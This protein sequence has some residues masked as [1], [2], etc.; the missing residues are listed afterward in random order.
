MSSKCFVTEL[1]GFEHDSIREILK[2]IDAN[3]KGICFV[4]DKQGVLVGS[5][6]DGDVRR[7]LLKNFGL[8]VPVKEI[9]KREF[10][11]LPIG[12]PVEEIQEMLSSTIRY[13]PLVDKN[14]RPIDYASWKRMHRIP[15]MEPTLIGNEIAYVTDCIKTGWI[16]SQGHYVREFE[17]LLAGYCSMPYALA[18]SNGT[19]ALHLALLALGVSKGDQ[20]I[21]PDIT[22]AACINAVIYTGATPV[23]VDVSRDTWSLDP[24]AVEKAITSRT[25]VIMSVH[26]YGHPCHMDELSLISKKHNIFLIEDCAEALG[27][28]YKD[29]PIGSFGDISIF[30]FFGNKTITTGEGGMVL[31]RDK[32]TYERAHV[33]RDHGMSKV[34]KYWHDVVGYNYRM[35][36]LQGAIGVAQLERLNE[37]IEAK[38][39]IAHYYNKSF[40]SFDEIIIPP[41]ET[42][43]YNSFWLY[44]ILL[45]EKVTISRDDLI[46]ELLK[47]GIESRPT[48][49]PIHQMPIYKSY[50]DG[51]QNFPVAG[52]IS[53]NGISLP[54]SVSL[55]EK[56]QDS[57]IDIVIHF[58]LKVRKKSQLSNECAL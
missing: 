4:V 5:V 39:K 52:Y 34:K 13:I 45:S 9:M 57:I 35:T 36:N 41:E 48:F 44:T 6:T 55:S 53:E 28:M 47:H 26:L 37:I 54:S 49:Y 16:S 29:K 38:R 17:S 14:F 22:F 2:I 51:N 33:L 56:E 27:G 32:E 31:I 40:S 15:V 30:S 46:T 1:I 58:V 18:V 50:L 12:T 20:V 43:A 7:A 8:D 42:W 24:L 3:A 11:S 19:V 10:L 23:L 25:K 21:L